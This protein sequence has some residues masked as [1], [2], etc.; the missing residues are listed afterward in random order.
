MLGAR[1]LHKVIS[2]FAKFLFLLLNNCHPLMKEGWRGGN[3][4][5]VA[6]GVDKNLQGA[7]SY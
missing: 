5:T 3:S 2:L 1:Q 4:V 7:I 6:E